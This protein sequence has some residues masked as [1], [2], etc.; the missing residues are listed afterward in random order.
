MFRANPNIHVASMIRENEAVVRGFLQ[1]P[2]VQDMPNG[3][4][5]LL[6]H[7]PTGLNDLFRHVPTGLNDLLR[8]VPTGLKDLLRRVP[9]GLKDF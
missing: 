7:V 4:Q 1:I 5:D 2:R 9:T 6:R 8:H 3:L